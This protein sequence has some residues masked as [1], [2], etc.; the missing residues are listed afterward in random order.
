MHLQLLLGPFLLRH[1]GRSLDQ[2][3]KRRASLGGA[4]LCVRL[5]QEPQLVEYHSGITL[6]DFQIELCAWLVERQQSLGLIRT[7]FSSSPR[8]NT[9]DFWVCDQPSSA[10]K[11]T[12]A[13]GM[14]PSRS[15]KIEMSMSALRLLSFCPFRSTSRGTCP[16][17]GGVHW[18]AL[19]RATCN[20]VDAIH[21]CK[22][23]EPGS[24]HGKEN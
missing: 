20:G 10:A 4:T 1:F 13:S 22:N 23:H 17:C 5:L 3:F 21:S 24:L 9:S 19:Y 16:N 12:S 8:V 11:L 7:I 18:K 15:R 6:C 2:R 14:M